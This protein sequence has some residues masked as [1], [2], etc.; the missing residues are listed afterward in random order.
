MLEE[1]KCPKCGGKMKRGQLT[2]NATLDQPIISN[3]IADSSRYGLEG[4]ASTRSQMSRGISVKG[5]L[6][7]EE[8]DKE[9]G[10]LIKRKG[11]Q[12]FPIKG[13]RCL[14]CGYIELYVVK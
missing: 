13:K 2:V 4:L 12:N 9:E 5:P 1:Q 14:E 11:R 6:W 10:W 3:A 8:S 7:R